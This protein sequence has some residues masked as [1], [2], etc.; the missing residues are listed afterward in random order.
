VA[1]L[2]VRLSVLLG[3]TT[4][5]PAPRSVADALTGVEVRTGGETDTLQLTFGLAK[6]RPGDYGLLESGLL[7]PL[8]RVVLVVTFGALPQVLMDGVITDQQV[9]PSNQPGQSVLVITGEDASVRLDLEPHTCPWPDRTDSQIVEQILG[10]YVRFGLRPDVEPTTRKPRPTERHRTQQGPDLPFLR[11]LASNNGFVFYVEPAAAPGFST[12]RWG[13]DDRPSR[14][15]EPL[16]LNQG[17]RTNVD[18]PMTFRFNALGPVEP[19]TA[20][21]RSPD[22]LTDIPAPQRP[23]VTRARRRAEAVRKIVL[24]DAAQLNSADAA[25]RALEAVAAA[26]DAVTAPGELDAVRNGRV[27]RP[28]RPVQVAG[29]GGTYGGD[30][31]VREV[32]HQ[33]SRG[34]YRQSFTL[35]REGLGALSSRLR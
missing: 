34:S 31:I 12:A 14:T 10:A 21:A 5:T 18:R 17:A 25:R 27:L 16:R 3:E 2:A 22:A 11:A 33:V 26:P 28:H 20:V 9:Q 32:T 29:V 24:R 7:D 1:S 15:Q 4:V 6:D 13:L 35:G 23:G 19:E 8:R 30:Y